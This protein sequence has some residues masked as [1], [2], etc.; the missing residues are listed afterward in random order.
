[1]VIQLLVFII[2][3]AKGGKAKHATSKL[4]YRKSDE[5][6]VGGLYAALMGGA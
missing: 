1:V 6:R 4:I 2:V 5:F 3:V